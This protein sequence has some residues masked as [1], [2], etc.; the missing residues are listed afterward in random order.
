MISFMKG[1]GAEGTK[2]GIR[3]T[4]EGVKNVSVKIPEDTAMDTE[5]IT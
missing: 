1:P 2:E 5:E 3:E 4:E